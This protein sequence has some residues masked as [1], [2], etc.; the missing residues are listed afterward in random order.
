MDK[1]LS[2][3]QYP[4]THHDHPA[5]DIIVTH[6]LDADF[7]EVAGA[8]SDYIKTNTDLQVYPQVEVRFMFGDPDYGSTYSIFT[9]YLKVDKG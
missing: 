1:I 8:Y 7:M 5:I 9:H 6:E 3:K 4:K 2:V